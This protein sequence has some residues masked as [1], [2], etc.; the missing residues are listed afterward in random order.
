[1]LSTGFLIVACSSLGVCWLGLSAWALGTRSAYDRAV[2][3]RARDAA[4]LTCE[5]IGV[6]SLSRR[7]LRFLAVA[8]RTE[9]SVLAAA[10]L[11]R[12][13]PQAV[14]RRA[15]GGRRAAARIR[16]LTI[17]VR[18]GSPRAAELVRDA[19]ATGDESLAASALRLTS[20]LPEAEADAL[21]LGMLADGRQSRS[22]IATE[23]EPRVAHIHDALL[24][25]ACDEDPALRFWSVTLLGA[26]RFDERAAAVLAAGAAD[27][28]PSV[29]AAAA[30]ALGAVRSA[31]AEPTLLRMLA[32]DVFYVRAHAARGIG[33]AKLTDLAGE[34]AS[35]LSDID[36]WVRASAKE[37][38]LE[39]GPAGFDAALAALDDVDGFA[40]DGAL[41]VVV[42]SPELPQLLDAAR[43]GDQRA[44]AL[45]ATIDGRRLYKSKP[46]EVVSA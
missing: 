25:L 43:G 8:E 1:M 23:L 27:P 36:W 10:E 38:L 2:A 32:D 40:R 15:A 41:E 42:A 11:L 19:M 37:A 22:R 14:L 17:A 12:R 29:R 16:A 21:L 9:A 3:R 33:A 13:E 46:A 7:R 4:A 39:L 35:L 24:E 6:V 34:I 44:A 28:D 45:V 31:D 20:E 30:E 5:A 18:S 26:G